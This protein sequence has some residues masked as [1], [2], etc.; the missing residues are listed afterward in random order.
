MYL[1]MLAVFLLQ[2]LRQ[3]G[4]D[5][6]LKKAATLQASGQRAEAVTL[7]RQLLSSLEAS[8]PEAV[9]E[10]AYQRSE[11]QYQLAECLEREGRHAEALTA[12]VEAEKCPRGS[13]CGNAC[14]AFW[15]QTL[16]GQGRC[17]E[18]LGRHQE[19]VDAYFRAASDTLNGI[20]PLVIRRIVDLYEVAGQTDSLTK[21]LHQRDQELLAKQDP[22]L[23][24]DPAE[25][26]KLRTP[27][28]AIRQL[29]EVRED[30]R[31]ER[32]SKL[33]DVLDG[34]GIVYLCPGPQP[35][36]LTDAARLLA[37]RPEKTVPL[38][39]AKLGKDTDY[40]PA[41]L[42][43]ALGLCGTSEAVKVLKA[44]A[45]AIDQQSWEEGRHWE[46]CELCYALRLSRLGKEALSEY[47]TS[48]SD[49]TKH[50]LDKVE[51]LSG[52]SEYSPWQF[53][54]IPRDLRLK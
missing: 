32:W 3:G 48:G 54:A 23:N 22:G 47:R 4:P 25:W 26:V 40:R 42:Y 18:L 35:S 14:S 53:P 41:W 6:L 19:A 44:K 12:F 15:V 37:S 36:H 11:A 51:E 33:V 38:I 27:S 10:H 2:T 20:S 52:R 50:A 13:F 31:A 46:L 1:S 45:D 49:N 16:I 39:R 7:Y 9:K 8:G 5:E 28:F 43:Y 17:L 21:L 34:P 29:I 24:V 30:A